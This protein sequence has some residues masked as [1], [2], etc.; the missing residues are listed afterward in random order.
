VRRVK[1]VSNHNN[2]PISNK[3]IGPCE[4]HIFKIQKPWGHFILLSSK[5]ESGRI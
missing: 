5:L 1:S 2:S 3:S 4:I